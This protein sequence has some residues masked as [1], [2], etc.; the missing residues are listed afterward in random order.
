MC[1]GCNMIFLPNAFERYFSALRLYVQISVLRGGTSRKRLAQLKK[2][3]LA[4]AF[5]Y[6]NSVCALDI[7]EF[8]GSLLGAAVII[9]L[10]KNVKTSVS[11]SGG[12]VFL[13]NRKILT[14][15]L[16]ELA[17]NYSGKHNNILI[18]SKAGSVSIKSDGFTLSATL[19]RLV[20]AAGGFC[21][22]ENKKKRSAIV[23]PAK[24]TAETPECVE[25]EWCQ[26]LDRFS[27]VNIWFSKAAGEG[28]V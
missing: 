12:G 7:N 11:F 15:V 4:E 14:A 1:G 20:K 18:L 26:I 9:M 10:Q 24:K 2:I 28:F 22:K 25:N 5:Y 23:L 3:S 21:L 17:S 19:E 6:R 16:M 13:L 27:P 8:C